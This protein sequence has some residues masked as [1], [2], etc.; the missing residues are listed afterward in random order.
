LL[1]LPFV[2]LRASSRVRSVGLASWAAVPYWHHWQ[3]SF[4]LSCFYSHARTG[5]VF[6]LHMLNYVLTCLVLS[7]GLNIRI[8]PPSLPP[9]LQKDCFG[10][11]RCDC[12]SLQGQTL[13]ALLIQHS[14]TNSPSIVFTSLHNFSG[15][16]AFNVPI[17]SKEKAHR[18]YPSPLK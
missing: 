4:F 8:G 9:Y 17:P 6:I 15:L 16:Y 1:V 13:F 14:A 11:Y 2:V 3:F 5:I 12:W 10:L 18:R 7:N